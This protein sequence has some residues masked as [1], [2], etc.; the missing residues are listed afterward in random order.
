MGAS[1]LEGTISEYLSD[2]VRE[3]GSSGHTWLL[4]AGTEGC[5]SSC[6]YITYPPPHTLSTHSD[7]LTSDSLTVPFYNCLA[8]FYHTH[9]FHTHTHTH[10]PPTSTP[11]HTT[12][13]HTT[14]PTHTPGTAL[15]GAGLPDVI[16]SDQGSDHGEGYDQS[17]EA[18]PHYR[19]YPHHPKRGHRKDDQCSR[20]LACEQITYHSL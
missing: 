4:H 15:P 10:T 20:V 1:T 12:T 13:T 19:Q 17:Q 6:E 7:S 5:T 14:P 18:W 9:T 11:T 2:E 8:K 16:E 3:D